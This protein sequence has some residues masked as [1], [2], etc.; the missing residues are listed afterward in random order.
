MTFDDYTSG[1]TIGTL[2]Y[3]VEQANGDPKPDGT[4]FYS[5][6]RTYEV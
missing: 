6:T 5:I 3:S 1:L 2:S 4:G